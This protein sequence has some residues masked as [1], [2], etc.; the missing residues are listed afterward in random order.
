VHCSHQAMKR[1]IVANS[2]I[3]EGSDGLNIRY[4]KFSVGRMLEC[5]KC[6]MGNGPH[7]CSLLTVN[8]TSVCFS[9][10]NIC[11]QTYYGVDLKKNLL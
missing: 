1:N 11:G 4:V 10:V 9:F 6:A 3:S 2:H 7:C 5:L 8:R